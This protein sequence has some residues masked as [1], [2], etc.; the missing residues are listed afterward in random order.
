MAWFRSLVV[1]P[2]QIFRQC[3]VTGLR[4]SIVRCV[5]RV[6]QSR[7]KRSVSRHVD[8][9][10][11]VTISEANVERC[12]P[13]VEVW[14]VVKHVCPARLW[15][16]WLRRCRQRRRIPVLVKCKPGGSADD[17]T[18]LLSARYYSWA[19][20]TASTEWGADFHMIDFFCKVLGMSTK[21]SRTRVPWCA[22]VRTLVNRRSY[23]VQ[24]GSQETPYGDQDTGL[25][26]SS[27]R[28]GRDHNDRLPH[29]KHFAV[30]MQC[31]LVPLNRCLS[32]NPSSC[33]DTWLFRGSTGVRL[34]IT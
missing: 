30:S 8:C 23:R 15:E 2:F 33:P 9:V 16:S 21:R 18:A 12:S 19:A 28:R 10:F 4:C 6:N 25:G 7:S 24:Q 22:L 13:M 17:L 27:D 31:V 11:V 5:G 34:S 20:S 32:R 26:S 3:L 1:A 29:P 14:R